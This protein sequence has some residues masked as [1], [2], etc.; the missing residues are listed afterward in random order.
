MDVLGRSSKVT[1]VCM[2]LGGIL[3]RM[4]MAASSAGFIV[5]EEV[6]E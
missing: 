6:V 3:K 1:H 5:W 4:A 2:N